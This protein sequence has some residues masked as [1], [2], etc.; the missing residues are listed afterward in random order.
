ML[1][2]LMRDWMQGFQL[3]RIIENRLHRYPDL[4]VANGIRDCMRDV[5]EYARFRGPKYL[6]AYSDV[7]KVH[8]EENGETDLLNELRDYEFQLEL[9]VSQ[10]TQLSLIAIGLSRSTAIAVSELIADDKLSE[11]QCREWLR[12]NEWMVESVPAVAQQEI[13]SM[14]GEERTSSQAQP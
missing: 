1:A 12:T 7:L 10:Q 3:A 11:A 14:L 6:K 8:L 4:K 2:M 13:A 9:G 5:E